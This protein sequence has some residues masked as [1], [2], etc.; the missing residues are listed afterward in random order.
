MFRHLSPEN[1]ELYKESLDGD[2]FIAGPCIREVEWHDDGKWIPFNDN[3][4]IQDEMGD[5]LDRE[6]GFE[7]VGNKYENPVL[8]QKELKYD[9]EN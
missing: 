6:F 2:S 4:F 8:L 5:W 1:A 9:E 7:V 3:E